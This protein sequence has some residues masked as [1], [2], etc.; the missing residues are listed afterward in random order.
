M[1]LPF[2]FEQIGD[3]SALGLATVVPPSDAETWDLWDLR[4][5]GHAVHRDTRSIVFRWPERPP[6]RGEVPAICGHTYAGA[7]LTESVLRC[8]TALEAH[9]GGVAFRV[10]LAELRAGGEIAAHVDKGPAVPYFHR[11]HVVARTNPDVEF[12]I[13]GH[14]HRFHE[15]MAYDIDNTRLHAVTNR[16]ASTRVHLICD[17]LTP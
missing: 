8:A 17:V 3:Y 11:C 2:P 5:Q 9:F 13:D 4:Q 16:G 12:W 6:R 1:R 7:A 14:P 10:V 15:G